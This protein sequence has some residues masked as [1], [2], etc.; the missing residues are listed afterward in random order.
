MCSRIAPRALRSRLRSVPFLAIRDIPV[1]NCVFSMIYAERLS[2][3][4][5]NPEATGQKPCDAQPI[6]TTDHHKPTACKPK[7]SGRAVE[8]GDSPAQIDI[9]IA[10]GN[11]T[12]LH[13]YFVPVP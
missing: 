5:V 1:T 7:G 12:G 9:T 6:W 2:S 3:Q 8:V 10:H 4:Y 11:I 13:V